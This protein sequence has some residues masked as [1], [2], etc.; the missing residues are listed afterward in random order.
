MTTPN[1]P[2]FRNRL[3]RLPLI[4]A[5]LLAPLIAHAQERPSFMAAGDVFCPDQ[6]DFDAFTSTG[7][8]RSVYGPQSCVHI[9]SLTRVVVLEGAP[10]AAQVRVVTGP[11]ESHVG[12][13]N[14]A[15][16]LLSVTP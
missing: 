2:H 10:G 8:F 16:P 1:E 6:L 11:F 7:K 5:L 13:T 12:Y 14:G 9:D 3:A 15:L 4:I